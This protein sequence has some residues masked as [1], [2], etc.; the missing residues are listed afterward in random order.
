VITNFLICRFN[1]TRL[2]QEPKKW[3]KN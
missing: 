2:K 1:S 3:S